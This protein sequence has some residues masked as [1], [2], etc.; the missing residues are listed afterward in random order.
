MEYEKDTI[1]TSHGMMT[2]E[3][4][5]K[6]NER[7]AAEA[8]P[9]A[10]VTIPAQKVKRCPYINGISKSCLNKCAFYDEEGKQCYY[11][12]KE[13]QVKTAGKVCPMSFSRGREKCGEYCAMYKDECCTLLSD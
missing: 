7:K 1:M 6:F 8:D 11:Q 3:A 9:G 4:L 2:A 5:K 10:S 12:R 13:A